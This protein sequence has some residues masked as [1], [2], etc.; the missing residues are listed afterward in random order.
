[1]LLF[2]NAHNILCI[3]KLTAAV[4]I[5]IHRVHV[6]ARDLILYIEQL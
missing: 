5:H 3:I 1:M 4:P 6:I 2:A